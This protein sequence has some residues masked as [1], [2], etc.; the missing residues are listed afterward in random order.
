MTFNPATNLTV[1]GPA[2]GATIHSLTVGGNG[3]GNP[4]LNL[5]AGVELTAASSL[6][7]GDDATI[8]FELGGTNSTA[9][10][11]LTTTG[12]ATLDGDFTLSFV[13][14]FMPAAGNEFKILSAVGGI[15]GTFDTIAADLPSLGGG[16]SWKIEYSANDVLL[17]VIGLA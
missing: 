17:S 14:S 8:G 5:K 3:A 10:S 12:T 4:T 15:S 13:N 1:S 7:L 11:R 2:S 6:V 9:F 16:L